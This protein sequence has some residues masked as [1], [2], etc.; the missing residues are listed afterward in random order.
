MIHEIKEGNFK[1]V[2]EPC[3]EAIR[4][5]NNDSPIGLLTMNGIYHGRIEVHDSYSAIFLDIFS[6]KKFNSISFI[7]INGIEELE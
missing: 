1:Y 6:D 5:G 7:R 2:K 4:W 3:I